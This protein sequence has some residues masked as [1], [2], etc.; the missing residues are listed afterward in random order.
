M[1]EDQNLGMQDVRQTINL[2]ACD[3]FHPPISSY[4]DKT[5]VFQQLRPFNDSYLGLIV[6]ESKPLC[7]PVSL[8][9]SPFSS[10]SRSTHTLGRAF[11]SAT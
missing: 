6:I 2:A 1:C 3:V 5:G 7:F 10:H 9:P 8:S 4:F 11:R